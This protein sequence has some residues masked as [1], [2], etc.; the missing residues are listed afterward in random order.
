MANNLQDKDVQR[1]VNEAGALVC[2]FNGEVIR[3]EACGPNSLRVRSRP[4]RSVMDPEWSAILPQPKQ[5]TMVAFDDKLA[6][7]SCGAIR[8][9]VRLTERYGADT[10]QELVIRFVRHRDGGE[11][12]GET[13][14]HF[15]GPGPR[16]FRAIASSSYRLEASFNAYDD[17]HLSGLGQ[18]QH[19]LLNL[20]GVSTTLLQQNTHVTI[21]FVISSRGY[22]F[23]WHN[24]AVGRVEF[25][26]NLT[27]WAAD[28][29]GQLDYWITAGNTPAELVRRYA[30]L[31]GHS[32]ALPQWASGFWQSRLRYATQEQIVSVAREYKRRGLPLSCI[33]IDFFHWTRQGE[34]QFDSKEWPDPAQMVK[35]LADLGV[36][37]MVSIW[38]TVSASSIYYREMREKGYLL[39]SERGQPVVIPFPD[40]E[41]FG[42]GF[43]TY[44]DATS[45]QARDYVWRIARRNYVDVGINNFWLDACEPEMRPNHADNTRVAMGNGAEVLNAYPALHQQGF[46]EGLVASGKSDDAVLLCRSAWVGSQRHGVILWSGDVWSNWRDFRAQLAAGLHAGL[47]G[48]GWWTTDVG[49][50]YDGIG[51]DPAFR[52]LLVRW[53][54]FGVFSP[55]LR[56]HGFRVPD[57]LPLPADGIPTYGVD[58]QGIFIK[59][60]G[61]N[62]VWSYG[63]DLLAIFTRLLAL[64]ESLR[65]YVM[66]LMDEYSRSGDPP[67][68]PLFYDYPQD[69]G[70]WQVEDQYLFGPD[71]LV[72]PIMHAG[73]ILREV[74]LPANVRWQ[75]VWTGRWHAGGAR[76]KVDAALTEIPVFRREGS[77]LALDTDALLPAASI[78]K[79]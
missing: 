73:A 10:K 3:I 49:G 32:P 51:K 66:K 35:D 30:D 9:E 78:A 14:S 40:K 65:P 21:P 60:G 17:E 45:P 29:T 59:G 67:M 70:C 74:Y 72:A 8:A 77:T 61:S 13:R 36:R 62:E 38:P 2:Q 18:P 57:E 43:F 7:I 24:P 47:S 58:T 31:T 76:I 79:T 52:E 42:T 4:G 50:F 54:Q 53:F 75:N 69:A 15:A 22:G 23:L 56:L 41:P 19:G 5:S 33:V 25:A 39:T 63:E 27:R 46:R 48:L 71:L 34:W 6:S 68:R 26:R 64:R 37:T 1:F 12:L 20:K 28:A 55:I 16:S 11:L 44:Y